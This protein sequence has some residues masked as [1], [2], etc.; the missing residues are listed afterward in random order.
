MKLA[1]RNMITVKDVNI[2]TIKV[3]GV[4]Y[5]SLTD[6]AKQ[7]NTTD[8]NGVIA[9]WMRN[10]NT[11][12]FLGLWETLYNPNFN[13]L[14]FEGFRNQAGLNA[15]TLSPTQW[16]EATHAIGIVTQAGRYGG[17]Y[18]SKDN[19]QYENNPINI[20]NISGTEYDAATITLGGTWRMPTKA[21]LEE[22]AKNCTR[23][24]ITLN[25]TVCMELTGPNGNKL[26]IARGGLGEQGTTHEDGYGLWSSTKFSASTAYRAWEWTYISFSYTWQGIPIRPVRDKNTED[27]KCE[28]PTISLL[29]GK[30]HFD[31]KTEGVTFHYSIS[32]P[33]ISEN[34]GNDIDLS[35][36]YTVNV[37]ATKEGYEA[38]NI[39]TAE[40][41]IRGLKGDV[42][43]DGEVNVGDIVTTTNIMAGKDE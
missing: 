10:R 31:C 30:L 33:E 20:N 3:E 7:K 35:S 19:Y 5:I 27:N 16:I 13:P 38:S 15:F 21:E 42:N 22:L 14:E 12:E 43:A 29:G 4:D 6:I 28:T 9:N 11:I 36:I 25:G 39:T 40:I 32:Y 41:D 17:T 26:I 1:K 24:Q 23:N 8:P 37:Y 2:R 18:F 34:T